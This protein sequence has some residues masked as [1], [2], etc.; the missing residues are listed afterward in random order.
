MGTIKCGFWTLSFIASPDEFKDFIKHCED[1]N[2]H[3]RDSDVCQQYQDFYNA[4]TATTAPI[5]LLKRDNISYINLRSFVC[6][7]EIENATGFSIVPATMV[8][9]IYHDKVV[10]I[11]DW[12]V[13][14]C[15]QK[16]VIVDKKDEKGDCFIYED[17]QLHSPTSHPLYQQATSFIKGITKPLRFTTNTVDGTDEIKPPVRISKKASVDLASSWIFKNCDFTMKS[18][19]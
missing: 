9:W 10:R 2:I 18:Y 19:V 11:H 12:A 6:S 3:S 4:L 8:H 17:I 15:L 16:A 5:N 1:L 14:I 13:Q 7:L